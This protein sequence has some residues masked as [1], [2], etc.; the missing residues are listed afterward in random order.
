MVG[1][2]DQSTVL[3]ENVIVKSLFCTRK[4]IIFAFIYLWACGGV[5]VRNAKVYEWRRQETNLKN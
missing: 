3:Y 4:L 5:P 1:G 2:Y